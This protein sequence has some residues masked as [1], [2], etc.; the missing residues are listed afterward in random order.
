MLSQ[1]LKYKKWDAERKILLCFRPDSHELIGRLNP[2]GALIK[3]MNVFNLMC[4]H[5]QASL[6]AAT[7]RI[8]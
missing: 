1:P 7:H 6:E 8:Q 5:P 4:D 2:V 3:V